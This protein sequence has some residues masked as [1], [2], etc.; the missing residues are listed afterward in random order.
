MALRRHL[1]PR[2]KCD[3]CRRFTAYAALSDCARNKHLACVISI[4]TDQQA[5]SWWMTRDLDGTPCV[6]DLAHEFSRWPFAPEEV[7]FLIQMAWLPRSMW[8]SV[9]CRHIQT[10]TQGQ[11]EAQNEQHEDA[12]EIVKFADTKTN[13]NIGIKTVASESS[14]QRPGAPPGGERESDLSRQTRPIGR[15][16]RRPI[17]REPP[18]QRARPRRGRARRRRRRAWDRTGSIPAC[19]STPSSA[20]I[21]RACWSPMLDPAAIAYS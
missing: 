5:A 21:G 8:V 20:S 17:G 11:A 15:R 4:C 1:S 7:V 12:N 10:R 18:G 6:F 14:S 9:P 16:R 19:T 2:R 3:T 13:I